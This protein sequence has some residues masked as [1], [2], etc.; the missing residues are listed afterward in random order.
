M[1]C[2]KGLSTGARALAPSVNKGHIIGWN[3]TYYFFHNT[4]NTMRNFLIIRKRSN[5]IFTMLI[6]E[7]EFSFPS[8]SLSGSTG[9]ATLDVSIDVVSGSFCFILKLTPLLLAE[10]PAPNRGESVPE[11]VYNQ[12]HC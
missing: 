6:N 12:S 8:S 10:R 1:L 4:F 9:S 7:P 5:D 11:F 2:V 3:T